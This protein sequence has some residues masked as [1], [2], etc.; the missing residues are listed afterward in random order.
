MLIIRQKNLIKISKD[1]ED[2]IKIHKFEYMYIFIAC[3]NIK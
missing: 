3:R 2:L 1:K